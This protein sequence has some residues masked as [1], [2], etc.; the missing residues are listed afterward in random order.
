[1][2]QYLVATFY[3]NHGL[4][5][6]SAWL[7]FLLLVSCTRTAPAQRSHGIYYWKTTLQITPQ[8]R[9]FLQEG[10]A[11]RLFVKFADVGVQ[12]STGEIEPY[13]L[14][15]VVDTSQLSGLEVVPCFFMT[16]E[17]FQR[18]T[19]AGSAAWLAERL[20]E[21]L[22]SV[23]GQFGKNAQDWPVIQV[24]CD[25]TATTR[26]AYF[27]FLGQLRQLLPLTEIQATIRLHQYRDPEHTGVP[28]VQRGTLMCYNTGEI[29]DENT[30]NSIFSLHDAAQYTAKADYPIPLDLALPMFRWALIFRDGALW[31]IVPE[32]DDAA[33]SDGLKFEQEGRFFRVKQ[34][35]FFGGNYLALGDRVKIETIEPA[36]L[37][38]ARP[39]FQQLRLAPDA[40]LLLYHL[41]SAAVARGDWWANCPW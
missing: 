25:W 37:A 6:Q 22:G 32:P 7:L 38:Q 9:Q 8:L 1:M 34:A 19:D 20:V 29:G 12:P 40:T 26:R 13:A 16:N 24:D 5:S 33:L 23:G 11:R 21:S 27:G 15:Q 35:T 3:R 18:A 28:P 14:L 31:R 36:T 4:I 10:A 30:K 41:D 2:I 39:Y 17:V